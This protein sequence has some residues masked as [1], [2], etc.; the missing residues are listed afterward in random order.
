[1]ARVTKTSD[2]LRKLESKRYN[3]CNELTVL[4]N[5]WKKSLDINKLSEFLKIIEDEKGSIKPKYLGENTYINL[6]AIAFEEFCFDLLSKVIKETGIE[7][8]VELFWNKKILTEEFYI[9]KNGQFDK[10]P[11]YKTVDI[12]IGKSEGKLFHSLV[13]IS[14]KIWQST[15]WLDEDRAVFDNIRNRYPNT[16]WYS[17]CMK[18]DVPPVSLI[19]SRRT[20]LR[21]FNLS[22][23]DEFNKFNEDIKKVLMEVKKSD[24]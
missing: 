12:V 10:Y 3:R 23:D 14:C 21:V 8:I 4:Y 6:K 2:Y 9:F 15:N 17:L 22:K 20:G 13:I 5:N 19:S 16:L 1:M 11:K 24:S 18:L 7:N